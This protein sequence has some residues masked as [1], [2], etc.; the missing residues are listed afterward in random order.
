MARRVLP[1]SIRIPRVAN[2]YNRERFPE[3]LEAPRGTARAAMPGAG[4]VHTPYPGASRQKI[5]RLRIET[6]VKHVM[7]KA[8]GEVARIVT[9]KAGSRI[10]NQIAVRAARAAYLAAQKAVG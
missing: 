6:C 1:D 10:A 2:A 4:V 7:G 3:K 8:E 9:P 5:E